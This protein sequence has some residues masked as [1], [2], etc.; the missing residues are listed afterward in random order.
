[1]EP[2]RL[3]GGS[4]SIARDRAQRDHDAIWRARNVAPVGDHDDAAEEGSI[5]FSTIS[6]AA[7]RRTVYRLSKCISET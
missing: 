6:F 4:G 2:H 7:L 3:L 1:M 5:R